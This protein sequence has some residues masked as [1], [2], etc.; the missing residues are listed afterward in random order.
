[1]IQEAKD[2]LEAEKFTNG[3]GTDGPEG[4]LTALVADIANVGVDSG[5][6]GGAVDAADF[7][8]TE[9]DLG[10]RFRSRAVWVAPRS[11]YNK[12]RQLDTSGGSAFWL[13]IADPTGQG[14]VSA[15]L[16]AY[17]AS[18][19]A[20]PSA[21]DS[22]IAILGDFSRYFLVVD[23]VGLSLA[24]IPHLFGEDGRPT[25]QSGLYAFWRN[26]GKVLN[27]NAFRL[28]KV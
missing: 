5:G 6:V 7:Y 15:N 11:T 3:D 13:R 20:N 23:R 19:F 8:A 9:E 27:T 18:A 25:G 2:D 21:A 16:V 17:E 1:M 24:L 10:P 12:V 4:V 26:S 14:K 22:P 28:L